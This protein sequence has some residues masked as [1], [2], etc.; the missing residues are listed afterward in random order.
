MFTVGRPARGH[1]I[2]AMLLGLLFL[3]SGLGAWALTSSQLSEQNITVAADAPFMAGARVN[4]PLAAFAQSEIINTHALAATNGLT[5]AEMEQ[6][7][8]LRETAQT[9]SFLRASLFTSILAFGLSLLLIG[10][11][12]LSMI[13]GHAIMKLSPRRMS[14]MGGGAPG[15]PQVVDGGFVNPGYDTTYGRVTETLTDTAIDTERITT[16]R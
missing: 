8:P 13:L 10:L 12:I 14:S 6:G 9:A 15:T 2:L 1:G 7:D 16:T 5:F 3:L 4:N 11:G